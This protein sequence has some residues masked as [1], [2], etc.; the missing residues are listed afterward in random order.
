MPSVGFEPAIFFWTDS[1]FISLKVLHVAYSQ[2][3]YLYRLLDA[4]VCHPL[5][6]KKLQYFAVGPSPITFTKGITVCFLATLLILSA[7]PCV[8]FSSWVLSDGCGLLV[9]D[10]L[11]ML[12][13]VV[14][15][16]P[17]MCPPYLDGVPLSLGSSEHLQIPSRFISSWRSVIRFPPRPPQEV[18]IIKQGQGPRGLQLIGHEVCQDP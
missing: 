13:S 12:Y 11:L 4:A 1:N 6:H 14:S 17:L 7:R 2:C 8:R 5:L 9:L 3:W 10:Y 16:R 18:H 15:L